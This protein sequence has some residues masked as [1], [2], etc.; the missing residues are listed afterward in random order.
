M[1]AVSLG[2]GNYREGGVDLKCASG[3]ETGNFL[4]LCHIC[5]P[6]REGGRVKEKITPTIRMCLLRQSLFSQEFSSASLLF[7]PP[8]F[9][10]PGLRCY[11]ATI[12][13]E[14]HSRTAESVSD[15]KGDIII[16]AIATEF[17]SSLPSFSP[18]RRLCLHHD[19]RVSLLRGPHLLAHPDR[20][21]RAHLHPGVAA[22]PRRIRMTAK[23]NTIFTVIASVV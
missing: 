7:L 3:G 18:A 20:R 8:F 10:L 15:L 11:S 21:V 12:S 5:L 2:P 14:Q 1:K 9:R 13:L 17:R 6:L 23:E 22:T 19:S 16:I 4:F